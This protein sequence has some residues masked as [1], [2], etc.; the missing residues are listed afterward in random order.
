MREKRLQCG[1]L[2]FITTKWPKHGIVMWQR[3]GVR[4]WAPAAGSLL[5]QATSFPCYEL[6]TLCKIK[7]LRSKIKV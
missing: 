2:R 6:G 5:R 4:V 1:L 3:M 7:S